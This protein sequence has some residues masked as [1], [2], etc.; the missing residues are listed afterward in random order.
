ML[1][2]VFVIFSL[3]SFLYSVAQTRAEKEG[4]Y[5]YR[6][7]KY[8]E[9]AQ[10]YKEAVE[11]SPSNYKVVYK[12]AEAY[13]AYFNYANAE[14]YYR[15]VVE[16][17]VEEYPMAQYW[18]AETMKLRGDYEG[19]QSEFEE[20][21]DNEDLF[22]SLDEGYS[23]KT[24]IELRGCEMAINE[25]KKPYR[26]YQFNLLDAS[27][28]SKNS[29]YAPVVYQND[30]S[31]IYTS[32]KS[33]NLEGVGGVNNHFGVEKSDSIWLKLESEGFF[34]V[35]NSKYN[36]GAGSFTSDKKKYYFTRCNGKQKHSDFK[37]FNCLIYMTKFEEEWVEA[38]PLNKNVNPHGEWTSNPSISLG[39]D[40]LFFVSKRPGGKGMHDIWF[41]LNEGG[42]DWGKAQNL[43]SVNTAFI[44]MSPMYDATDQVLYFSSNGRESF[45]GLDIYVAE[46]DDFEDVRNAGVPFNSNKDDFSFTLGDSK[47]YLASNR[48]GGKGNDDIY[49]FNK[50]SSES[51]VV[52]IPVD[53]LEGMKS[54]SIEGTV[55]DAETHEP[56][57]NVKETLVDGEGN[58]LKTTKSNE[59]G[60]FRFDNLDVNEY[61]SGF[62]VVIE[63]E[64]IATV[65]HP[66]D[67]I[68]ENI[69]VV[70]SSEEAT[71]VVFE[72]IYF[73]FNLST[74]RPEAI[75]VLEDLV[76]Y[77]AGNTQVQIEINAHTDAI[78]A[79]EYNKLLSKKR[80]ESAYRYLVNNGVDKA[81]IVIDARGE[82]ESIV[83]NESEIGRQLNRRVEFK[84]IGGGKHSPRAMTYIV[85]TNTSLEQVASKFNMTI[86]ELKE[87]NALHS[88]EIVAFKPIRV[89]N[90]G[91][92]DLIE[93]VTFANANKKNKKYYKERHQRFTSYQ[94]EYDGL[95]ATYQNYEKVKQELELK[96][97]QDYYVVLPKNT[98]FRIAKLYRMSLEEL[99]EV[100]N[101]SNDK[102][103]INQPII[104]IISVEVPSAGY[105]RVEE[106]DTFTSVAN[107][108]S[109]SIDVIKEVNL[110]QGYSLR[111]GMILKVE[112]N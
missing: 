99:L 14:N 87:M 15:I 89:R 53:S 101:L 6:H 106:G 61:N 37:E 77:Y 86:D 88:D 47:G 97:Q 100:N 17:A 82:S 12:L 23:E 65:T 16:N 50:E 59:E 64:V 94:K 62:K 60:E 95:N 66:S 68:V 52:A 63:E 74:L 81:S 104:V 34:N 85:E 55:M 78:G 98:L 105:Y 24:Q 8:Y 57:E 46:G 90:I 80:G 43:S 31:L 2:C 1:R 102:I 72:N 75:K 71:Q 54:V 76:R 109:V 70:G 40:T 45:G 29:E 49:W 103:Y 27:V 3:L 56:K 36:E 30:S 35:V 110:M 44:D 48:D 22:K 25:L 93:P 91:D 67:V 108:F 4:D 18:Y 111:K 112:E 92:D 5:Y 51:V 58:E 28:N 33:D 38:V 41:S 39:G 19:A 107:K 42:E 73:D 84:I 32:N 10:S 13:K 7:F 20:L 69:K 11:Q 26:N 83:S 21:I 96:S 79:I 9:A